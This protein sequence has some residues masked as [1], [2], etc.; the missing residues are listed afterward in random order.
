MWF[1]DLVTMR[2]WNGSWLNEAFATFMEVAACNAFRPDWKRWTT[3]GLERSAAF[4]VDSLESTRSIELEVSSPADA[5]GMF[6]V[7]TYQK[8]GAVLR[9]LEQYLGEEQFRGG[10]GHYLRTHAYGNTETSDLWDAL[11]ETSGAS[12]CA[13]G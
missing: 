11:E 5:E 10:V 9:M 3:F 1:G 13:I 4:E 6:D 8:G 2:W 12:R 7:L